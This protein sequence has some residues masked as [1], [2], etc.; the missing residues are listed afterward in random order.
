MSR[1]VAARW[2]SKETARRQMLHPDKEKR[3]RE[4]RQLH[5]KWITKQNILALK[6]VNKRN[7]I[8]T[9]SD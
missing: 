9:L 6:T 5:L 2:E 8:N 7:C 1:N 4:R 3:G